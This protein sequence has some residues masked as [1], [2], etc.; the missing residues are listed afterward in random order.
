MGVGF[1]AHTFFARAL[2]G[3]GG[4]KGRVP[5]PRESGMRGGFTLL[6]KRESALSFR[7]HDKNGLMAGLS[8]GERS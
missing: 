3:V 7:L 1:I 2:R 6:Y 5:N 4:S 8:G